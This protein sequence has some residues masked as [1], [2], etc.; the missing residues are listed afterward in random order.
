M[1]KRTEGGQRK[2][3]ILSTELNDFFPISVHVI[4]QDRGIVWTM[5][6]L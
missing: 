6:K 2:I 5:L 3:S 1:R 4:Q